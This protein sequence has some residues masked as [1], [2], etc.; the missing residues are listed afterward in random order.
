MNQTFARTP[1]GRRTR[2]AGEN[3]SGLKQ[4]LVIPFFV[5]I[6]FHDEI[7]L[8][9]IPTEELIYL[10]YF[11]RQFWDDLSGCLAD[12]NHC[13][14][15]AEAHTS[16]S[17]YMDGSQSLPTVVCIAPDIELHNYGGRLGLHKH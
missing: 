17:H 15:F 16:M 14:V 6:I 13:T 9:K 1:D 2:Y 10:C 7:V 12:R 5:S 3:S 11:R 4:K 8:M